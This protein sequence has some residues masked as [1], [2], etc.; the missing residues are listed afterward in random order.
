MGENEQGGMLR[1]VVVVGL[2]ALIA[3]VITVGVVGLKN[4]MTENTD[5]AVS[6]VAKNGQ[7]VSGR[8]LYIN[9]T[10]GKG[11]VSND[12][13]T[14]LPPNSI[15]KE[16]ASEYIAVQPNTAYT[17]QAWGSLLSGQY[18]WAGIGQYDSNKSFLSRSAGIYN[19]PIPTTDVPNDYEKTTF[20]T[21]A[22]THFVRVSSRTYGNYKVKF[23]Q[24][25]VPT[26][27][28]PAPED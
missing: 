15:N 16:M 13:G 11:Y 10:Q 14:I 17:F 23:E 22:N 8:N 2:V 12:D 24:G 1:T 20:T 7:Q 6:A 3:A 26:A 4:N 18:Y 27:W 28:T 5:R 19:T 25:N 21:S 9:A